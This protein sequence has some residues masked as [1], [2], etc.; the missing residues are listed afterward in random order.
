MVTFLKAQGSSLAATLID[1]LAT[2][3][4]K[5]VVGV[6]YAIANI[7]GV[8]TGGVA[9]FAVNRHWVFESN[10]TAVRKQAARFVLV[11]CGNLLLNA[12]G[13]YAITSLA[14][15][16]YILSKVIVALVVGWG[17]NYVLQKKYVFKQPESCYVEEP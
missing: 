12:F 11:W 1:F 2:I 7:A 9:N 6:W 3:L 13:V 16:N 17:Y 10:E 4:L 8:V 14:D 15:W 5:E